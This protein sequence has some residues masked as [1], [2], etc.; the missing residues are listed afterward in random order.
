[1]KKMI[2][3]LILCILILGML[4]L[5]GCGKE[6]DAASSGK[7]GDKTGGVSE[8][9]SDIMGNDNN[10]TEKNES[11]G[12]E[13]SENSENAADDNMSG[14]S[15]NNNKVEM[16]PCDTD[17]TGT[18]GSYFYIPVDGKIYRYKLTEGSYMGS[19]DAEPFFEFTEEEIGE[20]YEHSVYKLAD[21][22]DCYKLCDV[23]KDAEGNEM[24]KVLLEY[25][26]TRSASAD[27]I[28]QVKASGFVIVQDGSVTDGKE[29]WDEFYDKASSGNAC[30]VR[31]AQIFTLDKSNV[32]E[33][34]YEAQKDDY[35]QMFLRKLEFDGTKYV[36]SPLHYDGSDYT[37]YCE[38][39]Y[40]SPVTEWKYLM[41][42]T[43]KPAIS[44]SAVS[45]Y[46]KYVF[47]NDNTVTWDELE[48]GMLSSQFGAYIPYEEVVSE[49][50]FK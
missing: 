29:T 47:T 2:M 3:Q 39:G 11:A 18:Y 10:T 40:D 26:P 37:V 49:Y 36:S 30:E 15:E 13:E 5:S 41:H 44:T 42:Y 4:C 34:L 6:S 32:S 21:A 43:G 17:R 33:E 31:I 8:E 48:A 16:L 7:K 35:P 19:T 9:N 27:E 24:S 1:M 22:P 12:S 20:K 23:M 38:E 46:D 45:E 25:E 50:K 28:E 14:N